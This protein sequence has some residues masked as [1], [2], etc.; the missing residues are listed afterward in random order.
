MFR[1]LML[2]ACAAA[3]LMLGPVRAVSEEPIAGYASAIDGDTLQIGPWRVRLWGIDAFEKSQKCLDRN[4]QP[5]GCGLIARSVMSGLIAGQRVTCSQKDVDQYD[6]VVA[7]CRVAKRDIG[8]ALVEQGW[9]VHYDQNLTY[10][11]R[12]DKARANKVGAHAGLFIT[13]QGY[14][15]LVQKGLA[16]TLPS[17]E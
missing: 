10:A 16:G 13:P 4:G 2:A 3:M 6:R 9:A 15:R 5:Y 11:A 12:E 1:H 17:A 8:G 14:R 7:V